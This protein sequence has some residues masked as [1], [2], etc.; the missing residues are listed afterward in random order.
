VL[1]WLV[2]RS[3][4][5]PVAEFDGQV[6]RQ[7]VVKGDSESPDEHHVAVD[8][9]TREV[10]WDLSVGSEPWRRLTPGT[11]V[12]VR[13]NLRDRT[14]VTVAPAEPPAVAWPLA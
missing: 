9:G 12:H 5:P 4:P 11:F 7:W 6:I 1:A 13:V 10:A 14:E 3:V 2:R 8:D